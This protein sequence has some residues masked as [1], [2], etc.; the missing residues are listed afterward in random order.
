MTIA[1]WWHLGSNSR[2]S[3]ENRG[4]PASSRVAPER[5]RHGDQAS[6]WQGIENLSLSRVDPFSNLTQRGE[7]VRESGEDLSELARSA[8]AGDRRAAHTLL[9]RVGPAMLR[10]ARRVLG[11]R[12]E[13]VED[14]VQEAMQAL[15]DALPRFRGQCTVPHFAWRVAVL[16]AL[17]N[18]RRLDLRAQW[19]AEPTDG[20][21]EEVA[22]DR[23]PADAALLRGRRE[24]LSALLDELPPDQAEV[25]VLHAAY[26]FTIEELAGAIGRPIETIRSRLRL[27]KQVLRDRIDANPDLADVL[28]VTS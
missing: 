18:R 26:G 10:A 8:A 22:G 4:K 16:T 9:L 7:V 17:A 12:T 24:A 13:D 3:A 25:L 28:E 19:A 21:I 11:R 23:A 15:V 27:A 20:A 6:S 1:A 5:E 14:V 2:T